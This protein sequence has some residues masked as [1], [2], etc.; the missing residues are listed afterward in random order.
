MKSE[1]IVKLATEVVQ[2]EGIGKISFRN[3]ADAV[4]IK[5]SSVHYHFK[6]K[7]DLIEALINQYRDQFCESLAGVQAE[8]LS[9][10]EKVLRF[11]QIFEAVLSDGK[12]CL[13]GSLA[14]SVNELNEE[15]AEALKL[16]FDEA[17]AWLEKVLSEHQGDFAIRLDSVELARLILSGLE[18]AV[19]LDR[20]QRSKLNVQA[21]LN[22][23]NSIFDQTNPTKG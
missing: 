9:P 4:G 18:G 23:I 21:Q 12:L 20:V 15:A 16:F 5:S 1:E 8:E 10:K 6:T 7:G 19:L 11:A 22:F 13:C 14:V 17:S 2:R 3:L